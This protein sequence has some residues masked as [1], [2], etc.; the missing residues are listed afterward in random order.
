MEF[1]EG[2]KAFLEIGMLGLCSVMMCVIFY[3]NHKRN[4]KVD[5]D[6][7][8]FISGN[9]NKIETML[10]DLTK[11]VQEQNNLLI[12]RQ[13]LHYEKE[14]ERTTQLIQAV[15]NGVVAHVPS[16]EED[17]KLYEI[18]NI[19]DDTLRRLREDANASRAYIV[20][21]HNGGKGINRQAFQKMS[22]TNEQVKLSIKPI[23]NEFKDQ[24][25]MSL[26]Y[27][28][29]KLRDEGKCYIRD[30]EEIKNIDV[31]TYE[32]MK[33]KE[34]KSLYGKAIRGSEGNVIAFIGLD[35]EGRDVPDTTLIDESFAKYHSILENALNK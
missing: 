11:N 35:Y 20:Q 34:I 29:N 25:R 18:N 7:N 22:M 5:D 27:F 10:T 28:V 24:Y 6:K 33:F 19:V 30:V 14:N 13:E 15:V 3:E 32:F 12:E 21:Y 4:N 26:S 31:S 9:F 23:M 2:F 1:A 8:K 16:P 17:R